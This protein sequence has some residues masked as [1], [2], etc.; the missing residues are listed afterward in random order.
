MNVYSI[1][2]REGANY[3]TRL[4]TSELYSSN[5]WGYILLITLQNLSTALSFFSWQI[6]LLVSF[7]WF[8]LWVLWAGYAQAS[9][10]LYPRRYYF[11]LYP[12]TFKMQT[13]TT[14]S[15]AE[16]NIECMHPTVVVLHINYIKCYKCKFMLWIWFYGACICI[17]SYLPKS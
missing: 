9:S 14:I 15:V 10:Y 2:I 7:H 17:L 12:Q 13:L 4:C 3:G 11:H 16:Q 6:G 8:S 1:S 5:K